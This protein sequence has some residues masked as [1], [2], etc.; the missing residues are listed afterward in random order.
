VFKLASIAG[1]D[2]TLDLLGPAGLY[3]V[4]TFGAGLSTLLVGLLVAWII[5]PLTLAWG[6]FVRRPL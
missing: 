4:Q 2:S 1:F 6:V 3:A 5:V